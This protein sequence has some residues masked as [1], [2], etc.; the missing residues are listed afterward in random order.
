[1][2]IKKFLMALLTLTAGLSL[3]ACSNQPSKSASAITHSHS[4]LLAQTSSSKESTYQKSAS[5][6]KQ[7]VM[8]KFDQ[9]KTGN[10]GN[11]RAQVFAIMGNPDKTSQNTNK[12]SDKGSTVYTW[13]R[14]SQSTISIDIVKGRAVSK[15]RFQVYPSA[16]LTSVQYQRINKHDHLLAVKKQLGS[17]AEEMVIGKKGPYS[18]QTIVYLAK[19]KQKSYTFNFVDQRLTDKTASTSNDQ[20]AKSQKTTR[21]N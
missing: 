12:G 11:S 10:G 6:T 1:M 16:K 15:N 7:T 20:T 14:S 13:N 19:N 5:S 9:I 8:G 4:G 17:P 21:I 3:T 18:S 2:I